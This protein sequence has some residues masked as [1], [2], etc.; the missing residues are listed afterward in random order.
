MNFAIRGAV[1]SDFSMLG[2]RISTK[3]VHVDRAHF[4]GVTLS[5]LVTLLLLG[6]YSDRNLIVN[7]D[8]R[9]VGSSI[10][11]LWPLYVVMIAML[12]VRVVV[13]VWIMGRLGMLKLLC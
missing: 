10:V 6:C 2:G 4:P 13:S 3:L 7:V 1:K 8:V 11:L 12:D 5:I 9:V